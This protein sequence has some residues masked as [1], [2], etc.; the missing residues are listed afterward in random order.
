MTAYKALI[1]EITEYL[2]SPGILKA[3]IDPA[4]YAEEVV[5]E[6]EIRDGELQFEIPGRY[7]VSGNPNAVSFNAI[8]YEAEMDAGAE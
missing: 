8:A 1:A 7:T 3:D 6:T 5:S 4:N 2:S